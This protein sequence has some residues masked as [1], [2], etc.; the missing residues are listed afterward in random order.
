MKMYDYF[1]DMTTCDIKS[2]DTNMLWEDKWNGDIMKLKFP[3]LHSFTYKENISIKDAKDLDNL[4]GLFQLPLSI[5][6]HQ[7]FHQLSGEL[8]AIRHN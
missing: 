7:Q 5:Q 6:A 3:E 2:G 1:R 8:N 4:Y